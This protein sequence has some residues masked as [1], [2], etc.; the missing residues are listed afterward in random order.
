MANDNTEHPSTEPQSPNPD[1]QPRNDP[2]HEPENST[3]DD[4]FGQSVDR[5]ADLAHRLVEDAHGDE[6]EAERRFDEMA[7]GEERQAD[8]HVGRGPGN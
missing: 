4:W 1:P 3:V 7:T 8:R 2:H 5:D 6:Q